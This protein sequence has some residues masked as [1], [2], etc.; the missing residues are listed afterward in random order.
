VRLRGRGRD[1][2]LKL[3]E[4]DD[5]ET[6]AIVLLGDL[7]DL[8]DGEERENS[9]SVSMS[10]AD[11]VKQLGEMEDRKWPEY[12]G[13]KPIT[14]TQIAALLKPFQIWPRKVQDRDRRRQ[15]QGYRFDQF[16]STFRRYLAK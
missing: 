15:V 16:D 8:F 14:A 10:S 9:S 6:D 5:D 4:I 1:A 11:I 3:S 7:A 13:G 2:A 12:R